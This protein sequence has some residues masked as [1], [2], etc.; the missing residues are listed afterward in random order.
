MQH[1]FLSWDK[2]QLLTYQGIIDLI[3][4]LPVFLNP[5]QGSSHEFWSGHLGQP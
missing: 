3:V 1:F 5:A 2:D 4:F